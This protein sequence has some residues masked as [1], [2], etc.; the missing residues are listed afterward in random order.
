MATSQ[1]LPVIPSGK[2]GGQR[3]D[4]S[5]QHLEYLL[6]L[7]FTVSAIANNELLGGKL[8]RNTISKFMAAEGMTMPRQRFSQLSDAELN[9][10]VF[11]I[12]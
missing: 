3:L 4:I 7:G 2:K 10:V 8:H 9:D 11:D 5:K 1:R 12:H 6:S